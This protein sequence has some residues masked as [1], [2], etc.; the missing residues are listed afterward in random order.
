MMPA[1][2]VIAGQQYT[3]YGFSAMPYGEGF[4]TIKEAA[5]EGQNTCLLV[6]Q[7]MQ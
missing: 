5:T 1:C 4:K 2:R 7:I 6:L 3:I